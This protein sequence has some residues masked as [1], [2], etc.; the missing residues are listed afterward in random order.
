MQMKGEVRLLGGGTMIFI[1]R[2]RGPSTIRSLRLSVNLKQLNRYK[3]RAVEIREK[4]KQPKKILSKSKW[5][6][7]QKVLGGGVVFLWDGKKYSKTTGKKLRGGVVIPR[8][9]RVDF[10]GSKAGREKCLKGHNC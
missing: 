5:G 6:E 8:A 1:L 3:K 10:N 7:D 2:S 9:G 4:K